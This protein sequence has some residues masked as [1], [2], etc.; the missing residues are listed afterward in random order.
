[1]P[2]LHR[3]ATGG[4]CVPQGGVGSSLVSSKQYSEK[5]EIK[6][7]HSRTKNGLR[8]RTT[9]SEWDKYD[10]YL[11]SRLD[12]A[13]VVLGT[14]RTYQKSAMY[15]EGNTSDGPRVILRIATHGFFALAHAFKRS[16][17][18]GPS[19]WRNSSTARFVTL[20]SSLSWRPSSAWR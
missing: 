2:S 18:R 3:D 4:S 6:S 15:L 7:A 19:P 16:C 5:F 13:Q 9:G 14:L 8:A 12:T 20:C 10:P 17:T 11:Y 1:M